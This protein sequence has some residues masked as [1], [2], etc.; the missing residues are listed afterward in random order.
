MAGRRWRE[1]E[2]LAQ[3]ARQQGWRVRRTA[4]THLQFLA[5]SGEIVMVSS[6]GADHRA[7]L[8]AR[9]SLRR[10]GLQAA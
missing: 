10:A 4:R 5:P 7:I 8:N 9:V 6:S 2:A 3:L 1:V